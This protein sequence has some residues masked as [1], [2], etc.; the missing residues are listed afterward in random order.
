[1]SVQGYRND[2]KSTLRTSAAPHL[3]NLHCADFLV[4]LLPRPAAAGGGEESCTGVGWGTGRGRLG[5]TGHLKPEPAVQCL[6]LV[7]LDWSLLHDPAETS[8][9]VLTDRSKPH[10]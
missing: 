10:H 2:H 7:L 1:M 4:L 6:I 9:P 5:T 8:H 3:S